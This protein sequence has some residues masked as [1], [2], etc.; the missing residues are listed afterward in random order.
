MQQNF[1]VDPA[2]GP[3]ATLDAFVGMETENLVG[4][5][6]GADLVV[7]T[8]GIARKPGMTRDDLFGVNAKIMKGLIPTCRFGGSGGGGQGCLT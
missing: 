1:T 8:A 5:L 2:A 3:Q 4:A 6:Q 7:I